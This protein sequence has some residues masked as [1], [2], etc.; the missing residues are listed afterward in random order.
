MDY[1]KR[2]FEMDK[3]EI[4]MSTKIIISLVVLSLL[5]VGCS[6]VD[7]SGL[8]EVKSQEWVIV[9]IKEWCA[10]QNITPSLRECINFCNTL[11]WEGFNGPTTSTDH[12]CIKN[13]GDC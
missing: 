1:G 10:D 4:T 2:I 13:C 3:G 5:L 7:L 9:E 8:K 11:Y 6:V 12:Y